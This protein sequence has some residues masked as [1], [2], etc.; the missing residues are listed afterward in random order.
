MWYVTTEERVESLNSLFVKGHVAT[1]RLAMLE[2]RKTEQVILDILFKDGFPG[3]PLVLW[4]R[5]KDSNND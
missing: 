5:I 4:K 3:Q 1:A 2:E